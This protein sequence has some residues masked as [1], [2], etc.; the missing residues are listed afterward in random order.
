MPP[1]RRHPI[2]HRQPLPRRHPFSDGVNYRRPPCPVVLV[3]VFLSGANYISNRDQSHPIEPGGI[4]DF[5]RVTVTQSHVCDLDFTFL[6]INPFTLVNGGPHP[7]DMRGELDDTA[8]FKNFNKWG[9]IEF[10]MPFGRVMST[11]VQSTAWMKNA[12]LK[13]TVLNPKG[14][15]WTMVVGGGASVIYADTV[16]D[17]GYANEL[18]NYVAYSGA[19]N[20]DEIRKRALVIG[21]GIANFTDVVATFSGIIRALR[22]KVGIQSQSIKNANICEKRRSKLPEWSCMLL[23]K[24]S[25]FPSR[26]DNNIEV[27]NS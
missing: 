21:G 12:S 17:L 3:G 5:C 7:L 8:A 10:P 14:H 11:K 1:L 22:E 20:E 9:N 13:F 24:R 18:G 23:E 19:L 4:F 6:E 2:L 25:D 16:G 26:Y 15:I 27:L